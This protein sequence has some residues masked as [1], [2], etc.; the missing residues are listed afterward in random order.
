MGEKF[1]KMDSRVGERNVNKYG[2]EMIII[3]YNHARDIYVQFQD[4]YKFIRHTSYYSFKNG[5]VSNP[6]DKSVYGVGYFG[7]GKYNGLE[8][9]KI[10]DAWHNMMQRCYSE[11]YTKRFPTYKDCVVDPIFHDFQNFA[12]W[13]EDNYYEVE[14]QTMCLD[15]DILFKGNKVYSPETCIFVPMTINSLFLKN[16]ASRG[17]LPI[18][19]HY[20]KTNKSYV[21]SCEN[22][23][24][25][26]VFLGYYNDPIE[27]FYVYKEYK[28]T[29]I[30]KVAD[31]Y[32]GKIPERLYAAMYNYTVEIDD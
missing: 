3:I 7:V 6:Y 29:Y 1:I 2:T 5:G 11:E 13:Y 16:D 17:D 8:Y 20:S 26:P 14:N 19:V 25:K 9:P 21:V 15:K 24:R 4:E 30:K 23:N 27:A 31:K 10:Y 22:N 12:A 32:K 28:E 18:G